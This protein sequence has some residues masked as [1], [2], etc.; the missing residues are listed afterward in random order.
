MPA[1]VQRRDVLQQRVIAA[2]FG[3]RSVPVERERVA[4]GLRVGWNEC[5]SDQSECRNQGEP[6]HFFSFLGRSRL[7][8][9]PNEDRWVSLFI[10][11]VRDSVNKFIMDSAPVRRTPVIFALYSKFKFLTNFRRAQFRI[12]LVVW[13]DSVTFRRKCQVTCRREIRKGE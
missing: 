5:Q 2:N 3:A 1:F 6:F 13:G 4:R 11:T 9:P 7:M 10:K 8:M 12:I